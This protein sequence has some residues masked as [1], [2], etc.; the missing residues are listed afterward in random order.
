[1]VFLMDYKNNMQLFPY[2]Y[3]IKQRGFTNTHSFW[4]SLLKYVL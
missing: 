2:F 3:R 1:M 4:F